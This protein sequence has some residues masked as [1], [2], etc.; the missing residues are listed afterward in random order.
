MN[1]KQIKFLKT[2][3]P[4]IIT[5]MNITKMQKLVKLRPPKWDHINPTNEEIREDKIRLNSK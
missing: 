3:C 2:Y 5:E 1:K 4:A